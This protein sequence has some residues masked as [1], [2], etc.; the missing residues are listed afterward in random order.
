MQRLCEIKRHELMEQESSL[1]AK[2]SELENSIFKTKQR[3]VCDVEVVFFLFSSKTFRLPR[4][5]NSPNSA[6]FTKKRQ[7]Y[8][9]LFPETET[10]RT[11]PEA[12]KEDRTDADGKI[13]IVAKICDGAIGT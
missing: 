4:L 2:Q 8:V 10:S 5:F 1:Q 3:E 12:N 6:T 7:K 11:I 9:F 13:S